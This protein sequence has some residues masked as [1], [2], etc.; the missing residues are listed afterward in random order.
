L[1][2]T[3]R[4]IEESAAAIINLFNERELAQAGEAEIQS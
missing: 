1:D 3:R 4:S 2:V